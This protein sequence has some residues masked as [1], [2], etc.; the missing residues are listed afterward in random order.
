[1]MIEVLGSVP[2]GVSCDAPSGLGLSS[3][4]EDELVSKII[5]I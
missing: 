4:G 1:M 3:W 2:I 5:K